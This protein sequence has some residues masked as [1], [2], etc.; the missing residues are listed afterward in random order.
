MDIKKI[1]R[2][3][4]LHFL[5]IGATL[6]G[7]SHYFSPDVT[8][9]TTTLV[10]TSSQ[11]DRMMSGWKR[12]W[13]RDP[14]KEEFAGILEENIREE[15]LYREALAMGLE[16]DDAVVR[17]RL[18]QKMEY[19]SEDV[20]SLVEPTEQDLQKFFNQ[21]REMF[22][23]APLVSFEQEFEGE[24]RLPRS[25]ERV[26]PAAVDAQFGVGFYD[27]LKDLPLKV[28]SGP[29]VSSFGS[30]R[31]YIHFK[32]VPPEPRFAD[33]KEEVRREWEFVRRTE[34]QDSFYREIRKRY[35]ITVEDLPGNP[36]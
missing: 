21:N 29:V 36:R 2:E 22:R 13:K 14:T 3:P 31:I 30:H 33:V 17:R 19:L 9:S 25:L 16:K 8:P 6:F 34:A 15:I 26:S 4:L 35:T 28:W 12:V 32:E 1:V 27:Q 10:I 5:L 7:V 20:S 11:L 24:S 18:R 23:P